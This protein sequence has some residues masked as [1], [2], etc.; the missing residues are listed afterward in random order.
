MTLL[1][2]QLIL[3]EG[4]F[5]VARYDTGNGVETIRLD[6]RKFNDGK[7]HV[8]KFIRKGRSGMLV[9]DGFEITNRHQ[10]RCSHTLSKSV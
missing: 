10:G 3:Q 6:G 1:T 2:L 8:L 4:G 9:V 5:I 7:Y